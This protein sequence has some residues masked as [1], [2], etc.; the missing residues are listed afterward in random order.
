MQILMRLRRFPLEAIFWLI[1]FISLAYVNPSE[2]NHFTICPLALAGLDWCPGCGLGRSIA[3]LFDGQIQ[4]SLD[5]HPLGIFAVI[6]ISYR[7]VQLIKFYIKTHG[8]N[9]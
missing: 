3:Y 2:E 5:V 9:N 8:T 7:I 6:V 4:N 1:A